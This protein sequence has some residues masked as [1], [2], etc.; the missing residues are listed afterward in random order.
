M[1]KEKPEIVPPSVPKIL[2]VVLIEVII[3]IIHAFRL[4]QLFNGQ[5]HNLYYSY[6]SDLILPF[7]AY[8]LL[9]TNDATIPFFRKWYVKAGIIFSLTSMAEIC[10]FFGIDALGVTFDPIDI[11]MYGAGVLIAAWLDVKLFTSLFGFW[12]TTKN[13]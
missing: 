4:G 3:A 1:E 2:I 12:A 13:E 6:A 5:M 7:G 9:C 8:F 10:Q 11:C